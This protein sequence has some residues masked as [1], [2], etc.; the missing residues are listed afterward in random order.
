MKKPVSLLVVSIMMAQSAVYAQTTSTN[1]IA[2]AGGGKAPGFINPGDYNY[3]QIAQD[4]SK[5][6]LDV[7][8]R[9]ADIQKIDQ[10]YLK[11][12]VDRLNGHVKDLLALRLEFSKLSTKSSN[13]SVV[14]VEDY[15]NLVNQ[16]QDKN[17]ILLTE[18][19]TQTL[20][21]RE[22]LPSYS[23]SEAGAMK[24]TTNN[25]GNIEMKPV[26]ERIEKLRSSIIADMNQMKFPN[27]KTTKN[28]EPVSVVENALSPKLNVVIMSPEEINALEQEIKLLSTLHKDTKEYQRNHTRVLVTNILNFVQNYGTD[29]WL[30]FSNDND[31]EARKQSFEQIADAFYRRSYLRKKYGIRMGAI[32]SRGYPKKIANIESIGLE[33]QP[34]KA[35]LES[36]QREPAEN[37]RDINAA[38]EA[39]RNYVELWDAKLT[40]VFQGHDKIMAN[41]DKSLEFGSQNTNVMIRINS[42]ITAVTGQVKT[43]EAL[44]MIMR[45]VLSDIREER[46]LLQND[47]LA[48][49]AYHDARFRSTADLKKQATV[50]ICQFDWS[51]P[52]AVHTASCLPLGVKQKARRSTDGDGTSLVE[53]TSNLI[54]QYENTEKS[55]RDKAAKQQQLID[56]ARRASVT[57]AE[58]SELNDLLNN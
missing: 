21:S 56:A 20:I 34:I 12:I 58:I 53:V 28:D 47:R 43:A 35:A 38:F 2:V 11:G 51:L 8:Q 22:T 32:Q 13:L 16:I 55:K 23:L 18:I 29:E 44:L 48:L 39:A 5:I 37:D 49:A 42:A 7:L 26:M 14:A 50:K 36:L 46:M 40:P 27:M 31:A 25:V 6:M 57:E 4:N 41:K 1:V 9:N 30:R 52:E 3:A 17:Q 54:G 45:L 19:S 33:L 10:E 24:A 15:L